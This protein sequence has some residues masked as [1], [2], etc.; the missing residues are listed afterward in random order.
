MG[1][2]IFIGFFVV[3]ETQGFT[4]PKQFFVGE[5]PAYGAQQQPFRE[6]TGNREFGTGGVAAFAAVKEIVVVSHKIA[7]QNLR[8][9]LKIFHPGFGKETE[10]LS[11]SLGAHKAL[12]ADKYFVERRDILWSQAFRRLKTS[13]KVS[14][15]PI[16]GDGRHFTFG[17]IRV[18]P[19]GELHLTGIMR[20]GDQVDAFHGDAFHAGGA[21][22]LKVPVGA[23]CP[24]AARTCLGTMVKAAADAAVVRNSRRVD[25]VFCIFFCFILRSFISIGLRSATGAIV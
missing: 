12:C 21:P 10:T 23:V 8:G 20:I 17:H 18:G 13:G 1:H 24:D 3:G 11:A 2:D 22:H 14:F 9:L 5:A 25:V 15:V 6:G 19:F 16:D 4:V 7:F